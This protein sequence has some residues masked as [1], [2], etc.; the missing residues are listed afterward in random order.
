[1]AGEREE[2]QTSATSAASAI[3]HGNVSW[4]VEADIKG[5]FDA[6]N[7]NIYRGSSSTAS[8]TRSFCGFWGD[9]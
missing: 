3:T 5:F 7:M 6:L 8:Q 9:S 2:G 1:M 4:V